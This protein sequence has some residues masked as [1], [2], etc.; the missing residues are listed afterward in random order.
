MKQKHTKQILIRCHTFMLLLRLH[1]HQYFCVNAR[2]T[3]FAFDSQAFKKGECRFLICT[4]VAAR[5]NIAHSFRQLT[6]QMT[7]QHAIRGRETSDYVS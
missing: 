2:K 5:G 1:V 3:T 4:D 6:N 7:N